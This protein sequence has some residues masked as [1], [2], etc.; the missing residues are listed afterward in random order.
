MAPSPTSVSPATSSSSGRQ[1]R[2]P[3]TNTSPRRAS[4]TAM[5]P[6]KAS[7]VEAPRSGTPSVSARVCAIASPMRM[8]VKLPGPRPAT[9]PSIAR[10]SSTSSSTIASRSPAFSRDPRPPLVSAQTAPKEVAVSKAKIVCT[11]DGDAAVR[12][13][14]VVEGNADADLRQPGAAVLGPLDEGDRPL[15]VRLKVAPL[16]RFDA[17]KPVEVE[18]GDRRGRLVAVAD[19]EGRAGDRL[20]DAQ[21]A[22]RATDEGGL[23][24]AEL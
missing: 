22:R 6:A 9:I 13:V 19:R 21:R 1:T 7:S 15:E 11:G 18:V 2:G 4:I 17:R 24:G 8:L 14:D 23:A 20:V 5:P 12:L 10:G 16:G 3:G